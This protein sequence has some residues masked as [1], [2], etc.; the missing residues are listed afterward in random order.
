MGDVVDDRSGARSGNA[1]RVTPGSLLVA[2]P[3]LLDPQFRRTVVYVIE[4]R[5]RG[6]LGVVLN[7]PSEVAVRDVLPSWAPLAS[8][9]HAVFVGGPVEAETALCLA[10]V[11]TG[12]DPASL[13]GLVTVRAPVA[14]VDLDTDPAPLAPRL[15]GLRVFAG[16]AGW[17]AGQLDGEIGRG[18]WIV[19]PALPD[20]VLTGQEG[21]LWGRVLRR[22]GMPLSLLA[23][24]PTDVRQN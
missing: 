6:S 13:G 12:H 19:V 8:K 17:D 7:R 16:Y 18:D 20:D 4:H 1:S 11:R 3:G 9:P 14:L 24:Y 22:Q 2:A 10:A 15:R 21:N 5:S 23:T